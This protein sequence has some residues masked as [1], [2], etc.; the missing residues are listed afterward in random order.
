MI[1]SSIS[2]TIT[3]L[4]SWSFQEFLKESCFFKGLFSPWFYQSISSKSNKILCSVLINPEHLF[5]ELKNINPSFIEGLVVVNHFIYF[6]EKF[7]ASINPCVS[8]EI[9][10]L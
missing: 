8:L 3:I 1:S 4:L 9:F 2:L 6:V 10:N 5:E 7:D